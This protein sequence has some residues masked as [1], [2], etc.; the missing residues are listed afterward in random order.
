[1]SDLLL[2]LNQC[3]SQICVLFKYLSRSA[4]LLISI[5]G[6][7]CGISVPRKSQVTGFQTPY[8]PYLMITSFQQLLNGRFKLITMIKNF[9]VKQ[10]HQQSHFTSVLCALTMIDR[11]VPFLLFPVSINV[12]EIGY[13]R[14]VTLSQIRISN[15][16]FECCCFCFAFYSNAC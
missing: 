5:C 11:P 13:F 7:A 9:F 8:C 1:M 4:S 3:F 10:I 16:L 6:N 2:H 14:I 12:D 15:A